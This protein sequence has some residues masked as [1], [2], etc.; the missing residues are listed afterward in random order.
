MRIL[1]VNDNEL[2]I[3]DLDYDKGFIVN[4][5]IIIKHHNAIKA[6]PG[7][8]HVEVV[9]EYDNGGKDVITVWDE[10][11]VEAKDA[12]DETEEIQRYIE[13]TDAELEERAKAKAET[14]NRNKKINSLYESTVMFGD[15]VDSISANQGGV[16]E[17]GNI[18]SDLASALD[19]LAS[20]VSALTEKN[21]TI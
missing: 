19:D 2:N 5:T 7:K 11:P 4:E 13:Y 18:V 14:E 12:W 3:D 10:E 20:T 1:D 17:L 6:S 8:S 21:N 9:R 16:D 15:A